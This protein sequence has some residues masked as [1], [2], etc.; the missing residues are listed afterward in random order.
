MEEKASIRMN[1]HRFIIYDN[2]G[3][4]FGPLTRTRAVFELRTGADTTLERVQK[5]LG[6]APAGLWCPD[7]LKGVLEQRYPDTPV[8]PDDLAQGPVL[9]VD[10]RWA[11]IRHRD[12]VLSLKTGQA[13]VKADGRVVAVVLN[14]DQA[15]AFLNNGCRT[16]P[17]DVST[18][19][20]QN[21]VL[22]NRPWH[23]LDDLPE[24]L[25]HDLLHSDTPVIDL[26]E[27]PGIIVTG[28]HPVR[29]GPD[30]RILPSVVIDAEHGPVV[31]ERGATI[32]P[33]C[34]LQGPCYVGAGSV[35]VSHTSIRRNTVIGP[36]C[37]V[38]G[39]L[40]AS[41]LQS[42]SNKSHSGFLGDS[43]VGSWVNLG[44][45]TTTSNLKNTYGQVRIQLE[46]NGPAEDT[47]RMFLGSIIGDYVRT[48]IGTRLTTGSVIQPGCMLA[49]SGWAP[50]STRP[51]GF[52]TDAGYQPHDVSKLIETVRRMM[53]RRGITLDQAEAAMIRAID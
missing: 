16:L 21:R 45:G 51:M 9:L 36:G 8:N 50:G 40:S 19:R 47:G 15:L 6:A 10:G 25:E 29:V 26:G 2:E 18:I 30:T 41:I 12:E 17:D 31:I 1:T 43:L 27:H 7:R 39:E 5:T 37:K 4:S 23:I 24:N 11:G 20:L 13:L 33:L 22:L 53:H 49:V 46:P 32:N 38:G 48:A 3:G 34:V 28:E 14:N 35:L 52:Y 44:A 42:Y